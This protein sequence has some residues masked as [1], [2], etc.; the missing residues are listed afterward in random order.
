[1]SKAGLVTPEFLR[2]YRK[3]S[4][5]MILALSAIITPP[6]IFSQVLVSFPL[7][8]LYEIGIGISKRINI[9]RDKELGG[10]VETK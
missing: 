5:V 6:D 9:Q 10:G 7:I 3:H 2:K 1:L 4:L 8:F